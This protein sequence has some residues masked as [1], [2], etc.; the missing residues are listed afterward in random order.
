MFLTFSLFFIRFPCFSIGF[1]SCVSLFSIFSFFYFSFLVA[2]DFFDVS[3]P[4]L[5]GMFLV[6]NLQLA[7]STEILTFWMMMIT[8]YNDY[9]GDNDFSMVFIDFSMAFISFS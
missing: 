6:W 8:I 9:D 2:L 1:P 5:H 7:N 4:F 3:L